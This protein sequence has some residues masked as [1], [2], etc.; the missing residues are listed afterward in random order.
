MPWASDLELKP[1]ASVDDL[2][3]HGPGQLF[4]FNAKEVVWETTDLDGFPIKPVF[5]GNI[6]MGGGGEG[7]WGGF[8]HARMLGSA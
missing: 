6:A 8:L 1:V 3:D 2:I 7:G 5:L 4:S